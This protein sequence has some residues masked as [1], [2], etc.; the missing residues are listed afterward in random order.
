M[1]ERLKK[2]PEVTAFSHRLVPHVEHWDKTKDDLLLQLENRKD[3]VIRPLHWES[4]IEKRR[5]HAKESGEVTAEEFAA[6]SKRHFDELRGYGIDS[7]ISFVVAEARIGDKSGKEVFA[8]ISNVTP[9]EQSN[10]QQE[11]DAYLDLGRKLIRYYTNAYDKHSSFLADLA[12]GEQYV[13]GKK[14]GDEK[15]NLYMIDGTPYIYWSP[16]MLRQTLTVLAERLESER[17]RFN[18]QEFDA[19]KQLAVNLIARIDQELNSAG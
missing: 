17:T 16:Y 4:M 14:E 12:K 2:I 3:L 8:V 1:S 19:L 10:M 9:D 7:P 15:S 18:N 6:L 5:W 13:Y 11:S